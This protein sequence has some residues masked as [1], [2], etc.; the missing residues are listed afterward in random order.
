M[1]LEDDVRSLLHAAAADAP[2]APS[3]T[4]ERVIGRYRTRRRTQR[5]AAAAVAMVVLGVGGITGLGLSAAPTPGAPQLVANPTADVLAGPPRGNLADDDRL[6]AALLTAS[7][8]ALS[9]E[10]DRIYDPPAA[11]RSVVFAGDVGGIR[12]ALVAATVD[13]QR[14]GAWFTGPRGAP[15]EQLHLA[16][17]PGPLA[18][19]TPLVRLNT[20]PS[21]SA[22]VVISAPGDRVLLSDAVQVAADGSLDRRYRPL[23]TVDGVATATVGTTTDYGVAASVRIDRHGTTIFR[24]APVTSSPPAPAP[25][26]APVSSPAGQPRPPAALVE[27]FAADLARATGLDPATLRLR[28]LW[29]GSV[30]G[31][32]GRNVPA[33]VLA[34]TYP[35]GAVAIAGGWVAPDAESTRPAATWCTFAFHQAG[36]DAGRQPLA[37]RCTVPGATAARATLVLLPPAD[38]AAVDLL[39][40]AGT[41]IRGTELTGPTVLPAA[42]SERRARF[43]DRDGRPLATVAVSPWFRGDLGRYGTGLR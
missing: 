33:A 23:T 34:A 15:A 40:G 36:T 19:A 11:D 37:M 17:P 13:G 29:S 27:Q 20:A 8:T 4:A 9:A 43:L 10:A 31:A 32:D 24:G 22:L 5:V 42:G 14:V 41:R 26:P 1:S 3:G 6:L 28:A 12:T 35:S 2:G 16:Q 18:T 21:P 25:E 7:W 39:D 30:P 38:A